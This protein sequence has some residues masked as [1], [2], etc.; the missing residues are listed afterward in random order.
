MN[1]ENLLIRYYEARVWLDDFKADGEVAGV[2]PWDAHR[3]A[4]FY[5]E[6]DWDDEKAA[7]ND[8]V[9]QGWVQ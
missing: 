8:F 6:S 2:S 4:R 9:A 5:A 7:W 3:F 1:L